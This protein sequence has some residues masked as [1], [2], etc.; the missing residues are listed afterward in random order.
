MP[1]HVSLK[2]TYSNYLMHSECSKHFGSFDFVV[3]KFYQI[4]CVVW[5]VRQCSR[6][7]FSQCN[8]HVRKQAN[9]L[10]T[11]FTCGEVFKFPRISAQ[12]SH[13]SRTI[14]LAFAWFLQQP[15][16]INS[17][18]IRCI[19]VCVCACVWVIFQMHLDGAS[20]LD[21][22]CASTRKLL[23]AIGFSSIKALHSIDF[24]LYT[25]CIL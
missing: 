20:V 15:S 19:C 3:G 13:Q 2:S 16:S 8:V 1:M 6:L 25:S 5:F 10:Y 7:P 23:N 9:V 11:L 21:N 22:R 4:E 24:E 14:L 18:E 12:T 17:I